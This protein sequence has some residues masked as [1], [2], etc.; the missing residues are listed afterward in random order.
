MTLGEA[1]GWE[2][3]RSPTQTHF[4]KT[5]KNRGNDTIG[6]IST[7]KLIGLLFFVFLFS[8]IL[9]YSQEPKGLGFKSS[10]WGYIA[11]GNSINLC[12]LFHSMEIKQCLS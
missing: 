1:G 6:Y 8:F 4:L 11:S 10:L 9:L 12:F 7:I 2:T 3:G 5:L